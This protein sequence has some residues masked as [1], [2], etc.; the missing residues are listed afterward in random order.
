MDM[1]GHRM[2]DGRG[3]PQRRAQR[4]DHDAQVR[5]GQ[6]RAQP[7]PVTAELTADLPLL[8]RGAFVVWSA[9]PPG[10]RRSAD[11]GQTRGVDAQ[12]RGGAEQR[13][14]CGA[15]YCVTPTH[16]VGQDQQGPGVLG[17]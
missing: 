16:N 6:R 4:R 2:T 9:G 8:T 1:S 13:R 17:S 5:V 7:G 15:T 10:P 11:I 3:Q 12:L 14:R